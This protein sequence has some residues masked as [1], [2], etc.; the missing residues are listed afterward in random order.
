[1]MPLFINKRKLLLFCLPLLFPL[2]L[3]YV[4][5]RADINKSCNN[6]FSEIDAP[7]LMTNDLGIP[8]QNYYHGFPLIR[9]TK[10][11]LFIQNCV[12]PCREKVYSIVNLRDG[13][14]IPVEKNFSENFF[15][16]ISE[17]NLKE[18]G[19]ILKIE[20]FAIKEVL[21]DGILIRKSYLDFD[22]NKNT[23]MAS[24]ILQEKLV[25]NDK[26]GYLK[27]ILSKQAYRTYWT[28]GSRFLITSYGNSYDTPAEK[29]PP[30]IILF[31]K[32]EGTPFK[33]EVPNPSDIELSNIYKDDYMAFC[34]NTIGTVA[35]HNE[36]LLYGIAFY[37]GEG[38]K[39]LGGMG[40]IDFNSGESTFYR[41]D[42][43]IKYSVQKILPLE[44]DLL[45]IVP[46][47]E[48]EGWSGRWN[49]PWIYNTKKGEWKE[50]T[51]IRKGE[52][53]LDANKDGYSLWLATDRKLY[54]F[55]ATL[56]EAPKIYTF[57]EDRKNLVRI[58]KE[59]MSRSLRG[60][61][62]QRLWGI[63]W[64]SEEPIGDIKEELLSL[65]KDD[66]R[67]IQKL[68]L[69]GIGRGKIAETL[70]ILKSMKKDIYLANFVIFALYSI[71]GDAAKKVIE[72]FCSEKVAGY[73][74]PSIEAL[75]CMDNGISSLKK[76]LNI[77]DPYSLKSIVYHLSK[78]KDKE[79]V[80]LLLNLAER[81][82]LARKTQSEFYSRR[83]P[84]HGLNQTLISSFGEM[85]DERAIGW[86]KKEYKENKDIET[87]LMV[88]DAI[89]AILRTDAIP[90]LKEIK[91]RELNPRI[92]DKVDKLL[93]V[94]GG[95][96]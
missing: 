31:G 14:V 71:G 32:N 57:S 54:Q 42:T 59:T 21:K 40:S 74:K 73:C 17:I 37:G 79:I 95:R 3:T 1:M 44:E 29:Q 92:L 18:E 55:N 34:G 66:N 6:P 45:L 15:W 56:N 85:K 4:N 58:D 70:P 81:V 94:L 53:I 67:E 39:S 25:V 82:M 75:A 64:L 60:S 43:L 87:K 2:S 50:F 12:P 90:Y 10:T 86:L 22:L 5:A 38:C 9:A 36:K 11:A 48:G 63:F 51:G 93:L 89:T 88:L 26:N 28:D 27:E 72:S 13:S 52:V 77:D 41:P 96:N 35:L 69:R 91:A 46:I 23:V 8:F 49:G 78:V 24:K 65:L 33:K 19:M 62:K 84:W 20:A 68:A 16:G 80:P 61:E 7:S 83:N 30:L 76:L 47:W